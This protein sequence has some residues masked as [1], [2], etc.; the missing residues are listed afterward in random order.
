VPKKL[1]RC[2]K[3]VKAKGGVKNPWAVCKASL[4]K[5]AKKTKKK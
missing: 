2:V 3:K 1:D 4:A 5:K